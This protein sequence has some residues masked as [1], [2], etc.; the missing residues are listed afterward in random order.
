[1][2]NFTF[3]LLLTAAA[4]IVGGGLAWF[5]LK[6]LKQR[7]KQIILIEV[8]L[9]LAVSVLLVYEGLFVSATYTI[10]GL[11]VGVLII[12]ILNITLPHKHRTEQLGVLTFTAMSLHE[13]PEGIAYGA[14]FALNPLLGL[15]TGSLVAAHNLP[16][17]AIVAIPYLIKG[18]SN[19]AFQALL[20]TQ[21]LYIFGGLAA[22]FFLIA[23]SPSI[24]TFVASLAAGAMG[25]IGLEELKYFK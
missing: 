15:A 17:G 23:L 14:A 19:T 7:K 5:S 21:L 3:L 1:M 9:M 18:K 12:H 20:I 16:E 22:Y 13:F 25:Y 4:Q 2:M 6:K 8:A 10:F 11:L 24:Q